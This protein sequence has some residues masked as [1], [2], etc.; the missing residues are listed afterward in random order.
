MKSEIKIIDELYIS[1]FNSIRLEKEQTN[2]SINS[3]ELKDIEK[4][5]VLLEKLNEEK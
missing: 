2:A 3:H 1:E 4:I 5:V